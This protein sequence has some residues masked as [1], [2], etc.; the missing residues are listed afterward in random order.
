MLTTTSVLVE[1]TKKAAPKNRLYTH[2]AIGDV[3]LIFGHFPF[4]LNLFVTFLNSQLS[5]SRNT[6]DFGKVPFLITQGAYGSC[7]EPSLDTI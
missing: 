2:M 1:T 6:F 3:P 7:F 5:I 4:V